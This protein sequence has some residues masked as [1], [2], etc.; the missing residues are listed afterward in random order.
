[1]PSSSHIRICTLCSELLVDNRGGL[2][3]R[4]RQNHVDH[5]LPGRNNGDLLEVVKTGHDIL[6]EKKL[7]K[8]SSTRR[9][10]PGVLAAAAGLLYGGAGGGG[11]R[12]GCGV[13]VCVAVFALVGWRCCTHHRLM[14]Q[15][16]GLYT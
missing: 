11:R 9:S 7:Q 2:A 12:E 14:M 4:H 1:M 13:H 5:V 8:H 10:F 15:A 6:S 16:K 3:L